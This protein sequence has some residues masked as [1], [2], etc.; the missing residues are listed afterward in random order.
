MDWSVDRKLFKLFKALLIVIRSK[1][2]AL[3]GFH[4]IS[5]CISYHGI[6]P[7]YPAMFDCLT[8]AV[9][10]I[11]LWF[12]FRFSVIDCHVVFVWSIL[13]PV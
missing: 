5:T 12:Y 10:T 1:P 8:N 4:Q 3:R 6:K 2:H 7:A 9:I 11:L 13:E